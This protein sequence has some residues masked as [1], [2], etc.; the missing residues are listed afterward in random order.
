MKIISLHEATI[1]TSEEPISNTHLV[2]SSSNRKLI[3]IQLIKNTIF[4]ALGVI[5]AGFGLKGFLLPN[6]FID[7]GVT[8]ISLLLKELTGYP[9][10]LLIRG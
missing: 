1:E 2:T 9:L 8:G 7:G 4:I 3:L 6:G 10:S 5:S